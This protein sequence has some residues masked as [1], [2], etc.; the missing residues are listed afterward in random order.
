[1]ARHFTDGFALR[2]KFSPFLLIALLI[3]AVAGA[4]AVYL[5][6][7]T[8]RRRKDE[9]LIAETSLGKV[10]YAVAGKG[11]PVLVLHG[12]GG[13]YDQALHMT[14]A[15]AEKGFKLIAPSRF[16][17]LSSPAPKG[18]TP[19]MQAE[20]YARLLDHLGIKQVAV[21]AISAGAWSGL[22]FALRYP[23]RCRALV[24]MVPATGLPQ[25]VRLYGWLMAQ[26]IFRSNLLGGLA[27]RIAMLFPRLGA[28][29][30]GTPTGALPREE[31]QRIRQILRDGLPVRE[32][33][34]GM[35][36]DLTTA[37]PHVGFPMRGITAPVLTI[38]A[39]NDGF[40]TDTRAKEIAR[41]V[42]KGQALI[43]PD[44]GH[45]LAGRHEDAVRE[46]A[47]FLKG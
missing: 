30:I 2:R 42:A 25:S 6:R 32:H 7:K 27:L 36:L 47:A 12:A 44:G 16:G 21:V 18:A 23:E 24:L 45:L 29:L 10:E 39:A 41:T 22:H 9:S 13:G 26:T 15:L 46:V 11:A 3:S 35:V 37:H 1:M 38:S 5:F 34:K 17:Y 31:K 20:A 4:V 28:A 43:F 19:G 40:K 14:A 33:R 8:G